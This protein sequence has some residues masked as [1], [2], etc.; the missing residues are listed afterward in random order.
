M[1]QGIRSKWTAVLAVALL[2]CCAAALSVILSLP[3]DA[4]AAGAV[5]LPKTGQTTSYAARDDGNLQIGVAWPDPR[6]TVGTGAEADCVT[7]NLTGLMWS[8]NANLPNGQRNWQEALD[9]VAALNSG[10]DLCGHTDWRLPNI[11]ELESLIHAGQPD[12]ATWLNEQGFSNVQSNWYWS[13]TTYA[14]D[15]GKAWVIHSWFGIVAGTSKNDT[16]YVWPVRSG[17]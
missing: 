13:S 1:K 14:D 2:L 4:Y 3:K 17:Q 10:G 16:A 15:T 12:I 11:N 7:D 5:E 9:Y 6:F 8:K